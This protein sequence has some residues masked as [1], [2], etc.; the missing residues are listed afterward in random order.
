MKLYQRKILS[1]NTN[2]GVPDALPQ[3]INGLEPVSLENLPLAL[4]DATVAQLGYVDTGFFYTGDSNVDQ[5][6]VRRISPYDF[7]TRFT[8]QE[9]MAIRASTDGVV[10]DFMDLLN[11]V[12]AVE[13]DAVATQQGVGYLAQLNL[14]ASDRPSQILA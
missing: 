4:G 1:T 9:R 5:P 10:R 11:H 7:L 2:V 8:M 6:V 13:L 3:D 14:I 12:P